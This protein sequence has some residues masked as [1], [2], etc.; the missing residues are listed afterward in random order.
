MALPD[1]TR[2]IP[3]TVVGIPLALLI[4]YL[5][6]WALGGV[7]AIIAA[8]G[9]L[10]YY[11]LAEKRGV[12]PFYYLGI[13]CS[14]ALVLVAT[15]TPSFETVAKAGWA[16]GLALVLVSLAAAVSRRGPEGSPLAAVGATV[17]GTL[18]IGGSL[19]F[20]VLLRHL[21]PAGAGPWAGPLL[22]VFPL[23]II[24]VG[25]TCAYLCGTQ[26]GRRKLCPL[27]S[28]H[29]TVLGAVAGLVGSTLAA[30]VFA[31]LALDGIPG[32]GMGTW[33][34]AG[35]GLLVGAAGQVGDLGESVLK[36]E[37]GVKDSG[38]I[39]PGHGGVLDRFDALFFS[40]PATFL[41]L[42]LLKGLAS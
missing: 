37:A 13:P 41:L 15:A 34:G 32:F 40:F 25:D 23:V 17:T 21:P 22:L 36:R 9:S 38:T 35:I 20:A 10:E 4:V 31:W 7:L 18:L 2:R 16:L 42:L 29:K 8:L 33:A 12:R 28:P 1:L 11:G 26:W 39:F 30:A 3:V 5:G 19:S 14:A 6:G 27:V 24:W